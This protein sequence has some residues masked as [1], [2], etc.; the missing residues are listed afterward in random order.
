MNI[1]ECF[2]CGKPV[3]IPDHAIINATTYLKVVITVTECCGHA[4]CI[5]PVVKF[6]I[7]PY[8]GNK[9]ED[10]WGNRIKKA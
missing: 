1:N 8:T 5:R 3:E 10:D 7:T 9:T 6:D 2:F 4:I